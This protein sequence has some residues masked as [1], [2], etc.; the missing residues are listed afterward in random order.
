MVLRAENVTRQYFRQG[1]G[2][3]VFTALHE[4]N[5]SLE[6]GTLTEVTGRSGSGK[7]TLLNLFAGLLAPSSGRIFAG[8]TDLYAMDDMERSKFRNEAIGVVPQGQT[9]LKSL[10]VLE[11]IL[12]VAE[13]KELKANPDKLAKGTVIEAKLDKNKG[14][15]ATL[16]VQRGTLRAGDAILTE[17]TFGHIRRMTDVPFGL[18]SRR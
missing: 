17:T 12:L 8:D 4:T 9:G 13:V 10:T 7:S 2:T 5:L 15:V 14:P 3:N 6:G 11:N 1:K 18:S 16:L